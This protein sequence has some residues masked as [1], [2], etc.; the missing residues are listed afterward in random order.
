MTLL[1]GAN[2]A[3]NIIK[4]AAASCDRFSTTRARVTPRFLWRTYRIGGVCSDFKQWGGDFDRHFE[5]YAKNLV[6]IR[7]EN[8]V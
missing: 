4:F 1:C 5:P 6:C 8:D 3:Q 7:P 2:L